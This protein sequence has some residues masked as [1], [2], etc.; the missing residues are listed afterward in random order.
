MTDALDK[1]RAVGECPWYQDVDKF[2]GRRVWVA[3][4]CYGTIDPDLFSWAQ[5]CIDEEVIE[6]C[7]FCG[8]YIAETTKADI[9]AEAAA[10]R[11]YREGIRYGTMGYGG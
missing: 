9:D 4:N 7:P 2:T 11:E 6:R 1:L 3:H 5:T 10:E 8:K